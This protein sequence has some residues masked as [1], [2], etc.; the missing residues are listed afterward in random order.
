MD[1]RYITGIEEENLRMHLEHGSQLVSTDCSLLAARMN[2]GI[3][4][5]SS[6][7][8][9]LCQKSQGVNICVSLKCSFSDSGFFA[10]VCGWGFNVR[11]ES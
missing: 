5:D 10:C 2:S 11:E 1:K 7:C 4:C 3:T 6:T 9:R 8:C